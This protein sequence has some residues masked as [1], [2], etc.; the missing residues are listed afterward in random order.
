MLSLILDRIFKVMQDLRPSLVSDF[1]CKILGSFSHLLIHCGSIPWSRGHPQLLCSPMMLSLGTSAQLGESRWGGGQS[2]DS[3]Q[4][5]TQVLLPA[6]PVEPCVL[7]EHQC[8]RFLSCCGVKLL[9]EE[10]FEK[11][12]AFALSSRLQGI[13]VSPSLKRAVISHPY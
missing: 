3:P 7:S 10:N 6:L 12:C 11:G 4:T 13:H 5:W 9:C 2:T 1:C 8:I